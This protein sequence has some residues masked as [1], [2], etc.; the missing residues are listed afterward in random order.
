MVLEASG[1]LGIG[2]VSGLFMAFFIGANDIGNAMGATLG[3]KA[4]SLK[5]III[6]AIVF[7]LVGSILLGGFVAQTVSSGLIKFPAGEVSELRVREYMLIMVSVLVGSGVWLCVATLFSV[8]VSTT[9]SIVG[10]IIG[11][12]I[13]LETNSG[14]NSVEWFT[15][16]KICTAWVL[17]PLLGGLA[18][19]VC[20]YPLKKFTFLS[21]SPSSNIFRA[22]P[23]LTGISGGVLIL[24][25][26]YK[27][28][29]PLKLEPPIY[30]VLPVSIVI[31]VLI[32]LVMWKF[33]V[34]FIRGKVNDESDTGHLQVIAEELSSPDKVEPQEWTDQDEGVKAEVATE[35][36]DQEMVDAENLNRTEAATITVETNVEPSQVERSTS[37]TVDELVNLTEKHAFNFLVIIT[38]CCI[39]TAHGANDISNASGPLGAVVWMYFN[40]VL[41]TSETKTELW[42]TAV[43]AVGLVLGLSTLGYRVMKTLGNKITKL[44]PARAFVAQLGTAFITLTGSILNLPLSTTHIIVGAVYGIS[45]I[46]CKSV[47]DLQWKTLGGIVLSWVI[48]I[49]ASSIV[50]LIVFV[51]LRFAL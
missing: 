48:T 32:G 9:H 44:T 34:P 8:P 14:W 1:L 22:L 37:P 28:L 27:G 47:R 5:K 46:D 35:T 30:I 39:A 38:S 20:W 7:E 26:L 18:S 11:L 24:F 19:L 4:L 40:R 6:L 33:G 45:I 15:I 21:E 36:L 17:S 12:G 2:I 51:L 49:P 42:V 16:G 23:A 50:S 43:A 41:P 29:T 10:S 31:A 25:I 3:C 13:Y